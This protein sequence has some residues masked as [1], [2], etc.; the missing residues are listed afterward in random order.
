MVKTYKTNTKTIRQVDGRMSL[1]DEEFV[2]RET[3]VTP[4]EFGEFLRNAGKIIRENTTDNAINKERESIL[5]FLK[6]IGAP[7]DLNIKYNCEVNYDTNK[8]IING[9]DIGATISQHEIVKKKKGSSYCNGAPLYTVLKDHYTHIAGAK[10]SG[11]SL[12]NLDRAEFH[13]KEG[14]IEGA[15]LSAMLAVQCTRDIVIA[16]FE[17]DYLAQTERNKSTIE[18]DRYICKRWKELNQ[19]GINKTQATKTIREE[20]I[21]NNGG[22]KSGFSISTIREKLKSANIEKLNAKYG[23]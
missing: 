21:D 17:D 20:L 15:V 18:I 22:N 3:P 1:L 16:D 6:E 11:E 7:H 10:S 2:L 23:Y 8:V 14:N 5:S 9:K 12:F 4:K 19:D 13:I